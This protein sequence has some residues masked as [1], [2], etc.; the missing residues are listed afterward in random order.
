MDV[1]G[2]DLAGVVDLFDAL[3][4]EE[5]TRAF[6]ELAFKR[7][8]ETESAAFGPAIEAAVDAYHLVEVDTDAAD[9]RLYV[10]GPVAF[11]TLPEGAADLP[12]ILDVPDR[13]IDDEALA[14][15]AKSRFTADAEEAL[16]AGDPERIEQLVDVS[17]ELEVWAPVDVEAV[18]TRLT[19]ALP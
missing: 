19:E 1:S 14:S 17:Y 10:P 7:G 3:T 11:P 13:S 15:A 6:V 8:E 4:R 2:D 16:E 18:R 9:E 5:L 12:H